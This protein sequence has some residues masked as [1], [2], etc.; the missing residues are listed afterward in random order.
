MNRKKAI[1]R[2]LL[3]GGGIAASVGGVKMYNAVKRPDFE[4]LKTHK[5]VLDDLA[6]V[7]IPETD[8][9]GAK[10][11]NVGAYILVMLLECTKRKTA[12]NFIDGLDS[13]VLYTQEEYNKGFTECTMQEKKDILTKYKNYRSYGTGRM[14]RAF[15]MVLGPSF[16]ATLKKHT[17]EGFCTSRVGATQALAYDAIPGKY[18]SETIIGT[19]AKGWATR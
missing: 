3:L 13:L 1:G 11:A 14:G 17:V 2:I 19:S 6:E 4:K 10:S 16:F 8:T 18:E 5:A 9:P 12:N 15:S 7:I